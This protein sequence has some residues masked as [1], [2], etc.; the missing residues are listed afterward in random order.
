MGEMIL[1]PLVSI[2]IV[3]YN[4]TTTT[5]ECIQSIIKFTSLPFEIILIDN[6]SADRSIEEFK[7]LFPELT[8]ILNKENIG[9]GRANNLG[10]SIAKG[11]YLFLLNSDTLLTS[12]AACKFFDY[13]EDEKNNQVACCGGALINAEGKKQVSYGN[14]PSISEVFATLGPGI[15]YKNYYKKYLCSGVKI[16]F[17]APQQVDYISGADLFIRKSVL[18]KTGLFDEDFFLYFEETEL[19]FRMR[20]KGYLSVILPDVKIVHFEGSSHNT[21]QILEKKR[22]FAYSRLLFF[23]KC[24]GSLTASVAR[25]LYFIQKLIY[26]A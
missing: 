9:F 15:F 21:N 22:V 12:D 7:N 3:N 6:A 17:T 1:E 20:K 25:F 19:A 26:R 18:D 11:E 23:K 5:Y 24:N 14:F 13:M 8:L 2:I 4:T 10:I 16:Y